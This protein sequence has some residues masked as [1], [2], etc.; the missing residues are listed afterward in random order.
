MTLSSPLPHCSIHSS[1]VDSNLNEQDA[2]RDNGNIMENA[3]AVNVNTGR[4]TKRGRTTLK[5]LWALPPEEKVLV[6]ADRLGRPI[7]PEAQLLSSFLDMLA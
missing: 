3:E 4:H 6:S 7:G 1:S 5:E 2:N